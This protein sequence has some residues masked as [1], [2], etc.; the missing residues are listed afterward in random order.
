MTNIPIYSI[1][2][3]FYLISIT[4]HY[5]FLFGGWNDGQ[6]SS[7]MYCF[8]TSSNTWELVSLSDES[9]KPS[10]RYLTGAVLYRGRIAIFGGVGPPISNIQSGATY[11]GYSQ[12]SHDYGFG[13][14]NEMFLYDIQNSKWMFSRS[15]THFVLAFHTTM[16]QS[17]WPVF[18]PACVLC[19][20]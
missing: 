6:F 1:R 13:W 2:L 8:D 3:L 20:I 10:P 7:D 15:I 12:Y 17:T 4:G 5:I 19:V 18:E 14:N 11:I 16:V 9:V